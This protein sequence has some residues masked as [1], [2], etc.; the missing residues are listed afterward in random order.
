MFTIFF[1]KL[2]L[3]QIRNTARC[4][5]GKLL[6]SWVLDA[7]HL[8]SARHGVL[9]DGVHVVLGLHLPAFLLIL[10]NLHQHHPEVGASEV[11]SQKV[12]HL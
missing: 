2:Y 3:F 10:S 5:V 4:S 6:H 7:H 11:Q 8:R 1:F 12:T 9:W